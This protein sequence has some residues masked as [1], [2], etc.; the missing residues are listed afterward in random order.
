MAAFVLASSLKYRI[1]FPLD[2]AWIHQTYARNLAQR[3]EFSFIPGIPSAGSTAPL[4]TIL[5]VPGQWLGSGSGMLIYTLFLGLLSLGLV[6]LLGEKLSREMQ[7]PEY[8][9][10]G[11]PDLVLPLAG[12]ILA[13]EW[14]LVWAASSGMETALY[15]AAILLILYLAWKGRMPA[16]WLGG[17]IGLSIWIRPDGI[18]LLGPAAMMLFFQEQTWK[19]RL[20]RTLYLLIGLILPLAGY[21]L[22]NAS[23]SGSPWPSTFYAKQAEYASLWSESILQRFFRLA[24]LPLVGVGVLLLPGFIYQAYE[25]I[26]KRKVNHAALF[27]WWFGYTALYAYRLPVDYQHG[28][29]LIPAMPVFLLLGLGGTLDGFARWNLTHRTRRLAGFAG[30]AALVLVALAFL[31]V[32]AQAYATD[33]A[34]IESEMVDTALWLRGHTLP[35]DMLAVHDIGAVG[36]FSG[37]QI[38]DLAGLVTPEIIPFIQ[39]EEQI[40]DYL[41]AQGVTYLVT[42]PDWYQD[43][44]GGKAIVFQAGGAYSI[45]EGGTNMTVFRWKD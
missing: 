17:L 15:S 41:D 42:F 13:T 33:V 45:V 34:I 12:L 18:T 28:R 23:L 9:P 6:G 31:G 21:L 20:L 1:G 40:V 8:Q 29:Y 2:D 11:K 44:P 36:Y 26:R 25:T 24:S 4:W 19:R 22:F 35:E 10:S 27:L 5:L 39:D 38:V 14:H 7:V 43:L 32:G 16:F 3:G 30:K 37:R